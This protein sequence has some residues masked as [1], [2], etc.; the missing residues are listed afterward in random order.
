MGYSISLSSFSCVYVLSWT[1]CDLCLVY[2]LFFRR[3]PPLIFIGMSWGKGLVQEWGVPWGPRS[4]LPASKPHLLLLALFFSNPSCTTFFS[5]WITVD[6]V[7]LW[8]GE[9]VWIL[10]MVNTGE[11]NGNL[12]QYPCLENSIHIGAQWDTVHGLTES[13]N[14]LSDWAD[15]QT[16]LVA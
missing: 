9:F 4:G 2:S 12:L 11:G 1:I 7:T 10:L 8:C 16:L 3:K 14:W 13:W 15:T 6:Q 5:Q